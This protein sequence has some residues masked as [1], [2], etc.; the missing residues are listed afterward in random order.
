LLFVLSLAHRSTSA[1][2]PT[3]QAR[4]HEAK[5][6]WA[7]GWRICLKRQII[8]GDG[9]EWIYFCVCSMGLYALGG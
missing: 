4:K 9:Q 3:R 5:V 2:L 8:G 7:L 1:C 6:A